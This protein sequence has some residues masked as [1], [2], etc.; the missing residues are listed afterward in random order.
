M[1]RG[2]PDGPSLRGML[3]DG[4]R[5]TLDREAISGAEERCSGR[6][7]GAADGLVS[8][9]RGPLSGMD[10]GF[11]GFM[12]RFSNPPA[13]GG[14]GTEREA[15]DPCPGIR[16]PLFGVAPRFGT[17]SACGTF[18]V[19]AGLAILRAIFPPPLLAAGDAVWNEPRLPAGGATW[20]TTGRAK[21][22][23]GGTAAERAAFGPSIVVLV[24]FT[25]NEWTGL[26]RL[27]WSGEIRTAFR[28]TF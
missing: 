16:T 8:F 12:S 25:S 13:L 22:C 14:R 21:E 7:I 4:G 1:L 27:S 28:A 3:A 6:D 2:A 11:P 18:P 17:L 15:T 20:L 9:E 26:T 23:C 19:C 10:L 24:G 5:G